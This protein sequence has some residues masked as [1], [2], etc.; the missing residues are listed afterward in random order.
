MHVQVAADDAPRDGVIVVRELTLPRDN[1]PD[2]RR[3]P[4]GP[5]GLLRFVN[6]L[7]KVVTAGKLLDEHLPVVHVHVLDDQFLAENRP[8]RHVHEE[9]LCFQERTVRGPQAFDDEIVDLEGAGS[10]HDAQLADVHR[11]LEILRARDLGALAQRRPQIDRQARH[12]ERGDDRNEHPQRA[13]HAPR[14]TATRRRRRRGRRGG[15]RLLGRPRLGLR[16][17][18]GLLCHSLY[19]TTT[20]TRPAS[21]DVPALT[22]TFFTRPAFERLPRLHGVAGA[23]ED[24]DDAARHRRGDRLLAVGGDRVGAGASRALPVDDH[25]RR[26]PADVAEQF[27]AAGQRR[28]L[29]RAARVP[30]LREQHRDAEVADALRVNE[31]RGAVNGDAKA[32]GHRTRALDRHGAHPAVH[33]DLERHATFTEAPLRGRRSSSRPRAA[34]TRSVRRSRGT[35]HP[36]PRRSRAALRRRPSTR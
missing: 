17:G 29:H 15:R 4:L 14:P 25:A 2:S 24:A 12:Q 27:A 21:T 11:A 19:S 10:E 23:D 35:R 8:P 18:E 1:G 33:L 31:P 3:E 9:A 5:S 6:D 30:R 28:D 16:C 36:G 22:A 32:G 26:P 13:E 7:R 20:R 34:R